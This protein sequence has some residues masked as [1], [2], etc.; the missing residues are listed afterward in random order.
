MLTDSSLEELAANATH[1]IRDTYLKWLSDRIIVH[2][3][4]RIAMN[5]E[6]SY[7]FEDAQPEDMIQMLNESFGTPEDVKRHK[8]SCIMFNALMQ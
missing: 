6:L 8:T 4:I 2:C 5:N 3:T 7:K 1:A